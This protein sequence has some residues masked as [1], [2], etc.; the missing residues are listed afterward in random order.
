MNG[1]R[2]EIEPAS[3]FKNLI[4]VIAPIA[5]EGLLY[6][7]KS[8]FM[9]DAMDSAHVALICL[10]LP[11]DWFQKYEIYKEQEIMLNLEE[12]KKVLQRCSDERLFIQPDLADNKL[13][14]QFQNEVK[15][16]FRVNVSSIT[17]EMI[18]IPP[19]ILGAHFGLTTELLKEIIQ[20]TSI[21]GP[22]LTLT[23][24]DEEDPPILSIFCEGDNGDVNIDVDSRKFVE[25]LNLD[26]KQ[27][28]MYSLDYLSKITKVGTVSEKV[29]V[30]FGT[31][32]PL[33]LDF[34]LEKGRL[35]YV[36]SPRIE[37]S[38]EDVEVADEESE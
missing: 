7:D 24:K 10:D 17:P 29:I 28:S 20:D 38:D 18:T 3:R 32:A 13:M 27:R 36:L 11:N 5:S 2:L 19:R 1:F 25:P 31:D 12:I 35:I 16:V 21:F 33:K 4:N 6:L 30:E 14:L 22:Y 9:L 15:R 8:H 23:V 26:E 37:R 34:E